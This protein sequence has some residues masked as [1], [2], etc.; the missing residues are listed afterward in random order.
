MNKKMFVLVS[1]LIIAVVAMFAVTMRDIFKVGPKAPIE[2]EYF[3]PFEEQTSRFS[4]A[5]YTGLIPTDLPNTLS[6]LNTQVNNTVSMTDRLNKYCLIFETETHNNIT[7][8]HGENCDYSLYSDGHIQLESIFYTDTS[9]KLSF[10]TS[11]HAADEFL[12]QFYGNNMQLAEEEIEYLYCTETYCD[13]VDNISD[14]N[15][16]FL[17]YY[18]VHQ[19]TSIL[20]REQ[21]PDQAVVYVDN[22]GRIIKAELDMVDINYQADETSYPRLSISEAVENINNNKAV[23]YTYDDIYADGS[24]SEASIASLSNIN[25]TSVSLNYLMNQEN[26]LAVPTYYFL[27]TAMDTYGDTIDVEI[28]TPAINFTVVE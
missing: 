14:A 1:V 28:L 15:T 6:L 2:Q 25:L 7:I 16:V 26:T 20:T 3:V 23:L 27:G 9:G 24:K 13:E 5:V 18:F 22:M 10:A 11:T 21:I 8:N 19:D 12:R 4:G 17:P